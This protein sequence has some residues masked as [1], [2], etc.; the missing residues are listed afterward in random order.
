M[1][2]SPSSLRGVCFTPFR[3]FPAGLSLRAGRVPRACDLYGCLGRPRS[4]ALCLAE[5]SAAIVFK[6]IIIYE[7]Q[8]SHF[9]AALGP[10]SNADGPAQGVTGLRRH[11]LA[12][13]LPPLS[14]FPT[15]LAVFA[16]PQMLY[17][18]SNPCIRVCFRGKPTHDPR[19]PTSESVCCPVP[20]L[21]L[22]ARP[23]AETTAVAS[24]PFS[25]CPLCSLPFL[26]HSR[27]RVGG[28]VGWWVGW[29]EH[30]AS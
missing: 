29:F 3:Q 26:P 12:A 20:T 30:K 8:A 5:Y 14:L 18:N 9:R 2:D 21:T 28:W 11:W 17:L 22:T 10:A 6:F 24:Q 19:I 25:P 16:D 1:T 13:L 4:K 27:R 7:K 23:V 15:S